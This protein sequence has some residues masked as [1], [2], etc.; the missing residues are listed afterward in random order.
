MATYRPTP[1]SNSQSMLQLYSEYVMAETA[2]AKHPQADLQMLELSLR[3]ITN[4]CS[5]VEGRMQLSK[6]STAFSRH[7]LTLK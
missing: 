1:G 4:C 6:V 2:R 5:C 7:F 3:I